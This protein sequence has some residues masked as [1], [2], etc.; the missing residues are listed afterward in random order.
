MKN[1]LIKTAIVLLTLV[2]G[3]L[4]LSAQ[5]VNKLT[6]PDIEGERGEQIVVPVY[7]DNTDEITAL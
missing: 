4:G 7:L 5:T 1:H 3:G 6:V 2:A